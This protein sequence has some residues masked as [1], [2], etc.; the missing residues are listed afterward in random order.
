[1]NSYGNR[2]TIS[3]DFVSI[4]HKDRTFFLIELIDPQMCFIDLTTN[5]SVLIVARTANIEGVINNFF[6]LIVH[7]LY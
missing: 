4:L 1:M 7:N 6:F 3:N 5:S 2:N